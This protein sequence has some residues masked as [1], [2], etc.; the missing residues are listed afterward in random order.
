MPGLP[1]GVESRSGNAGHGERLG[2]ELV[3]EEVVAVLCTH[4]TVCTVP[5]RREDP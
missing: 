5:W 2:H 4:S 1:V 3:E